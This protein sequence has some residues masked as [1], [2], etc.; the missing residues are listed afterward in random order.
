[1]LQRI[2]DILPVGLWFADAQGNLLRGNLKG[3]KIWGAEPHVSPKE[4][5]VFKARRI[6]SGEP[7][8]AND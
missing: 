1:M 4:Y 2:F 8:E 7:V 3:I 6:P 5:G